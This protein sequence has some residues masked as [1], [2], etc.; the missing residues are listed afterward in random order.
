MRKRVTLRRSTCLGSVRN[1]ATLPKQTV[2]RSAPHLQ[3]HRCT[4]RR[5]RRNP[6]TVSF[7]AYRNSSIADVLSQELFDDLRAKISESAS[8][9]FAEHEVESWWDA[10]RGIGSGPRIAA[11]PPL[12]VTPDCNHVI[13]WT[14]QGASISV[15]ASGTEPKIKVSRRGGVGGGVYSNSTVMVVLGVCFGI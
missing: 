8:L 1:T 10:T 13:F 14:V 4:A 15:R 11:A 12:P 2:S 7:R 9:K 5:R 3:Q 6:P